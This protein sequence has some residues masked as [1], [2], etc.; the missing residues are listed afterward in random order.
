MIKYEFN[1]TLLSS[2]NRD[3]DF[4][5]DF[6][7]YESYLVRQ[8]ESL[9]LQSKCNSQ[10]TMNTIENIFGPFDYKEVNYFLQKLQEDGSQIINGFQKQL[11]FNLFYKYFGDPVSIKAIN[12]IDYI[13]LMLA[14]RKMLES[15]NMVILPYIISS[16]VVRVPKRKNINKKELLKITSSP[17]W[18]QIQDKY[19]NEKIEEEILGQIG[20]ILSAEFKIIDFYDDSLV[21][22]IIDCISDIVTEE[23]LMYVLLT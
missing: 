22:K 10:E 14:A 20:V 6:D 18:K 21:G 8:D 12:N 7:K 19:R 13:K 17:L 3:E 16:K 1:Y 2:S 4:N 11:I 5:S 9:Y 15:Y 23:Y